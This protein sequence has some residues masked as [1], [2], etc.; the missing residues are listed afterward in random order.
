[1]IFKSNIKHEACDMI[2]KVNG[3]ELN[4]SWRGKKR[5]EEREWEREKGGIMLD[6][7]LCEAWDRK[8]SKIYTISRK[9]RTLRKWRNP[10][11]FH[12][13]NVFFPFF[14]LLA[15]I[16]SR[17]NRAIWPGYEVYSGPCFTATTNCLASSREC[18]TTVAARNCAT[19]AIVFCACPATFWKTYYTFGFVSRTVKAK[20]HISHWLLRFLYSSF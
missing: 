1:M 20:D 7:K 18:S 17:M 3:I 4:V 15:T 2:I 19:P 12:F 11:L 14:S 10:K 16:R 13:A 5:N 8:K 6:E 9:R